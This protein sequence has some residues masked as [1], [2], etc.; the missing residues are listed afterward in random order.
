MIGLLGISTHVIND[1]LSTWGYLAVFVFVAIESSGIP[2]PGETMLLTAAAYAGA[3]HLQIPLVIAASAAG[4]M[5]GDNLGYLAGRTGGQKLAL[6]YGRYVRLDAAKLSAAQ[7][8]YGRH[9]DKTVFAGR[10]I[11]VLRAWSAFLAGLN[12]MPWRKFFCFDTAGAITWSMLWGIVAFEFGK[13]LSLV[14]Q[15]VTGVGIAGVALAM[16]AAVLI[17][18]FHRRA[19]RIEGEIGAV[20]EDAERAERDKMPI[21]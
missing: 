2:F 4:A 3:G 9:G 13:N 11:A 15:F 14:H 20:R 12:R 1:V 19:R 7:R 6:R 16:I 21:P 10:F 5:T 8:Y 18:Y 17:Y